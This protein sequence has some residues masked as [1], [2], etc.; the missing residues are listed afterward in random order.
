V[1]ARS[2]VVEAGRLSTALRTHILALADQAVVSAASF[3]TFILVSR[4]T[5]P[6]QLGLYSIAMSVL[7]STLA[8][9]FALISLPFTIQRHR[10]Q[11]TLADHAGTSLMHNGLLSGLSIVLLTTAAFGLSV[12]A[13]RPDTIAIAWALAAT[14]P[15]ALLRE[16]GRRCAFARL[17]MGEALLLDLA[18][19]AFQFGTLYW[20]GS[21]GHISPA[22]ACAAQGAACALVGILWLYLCRADFSIRND[23]ALAAAKQSW[24]LG[25]WF[26]A[27]QA[28]VWLQC[29]ITYWLLAFVHG[30]AATGVYAACMSLASFGNP[31]MTGINNA[32]IP[33]AVLALET[34]G[35]A[36][37]RKQAVRGAVLLGAAMG[38]FCLMLALFSAD[39]MRLIYRGKD[40]DGR[41]DTVAL[42]G[43]GLLVAA[44]GSPASF[45]LA[46]LERPQAIVWSGLLGLVFTVIL[47]LVLMAEWNLFGAAC[48]YATG[49]VAATA[50]LWVAFL[51]VL[52]ERGS[53]PPQSAALAAWTAARPVGH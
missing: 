39:A 51:A 48:G 41:G 31:L 30:S 18:V 40:F 33:K 3:L 23:Q 21:T 46:S 12:S 28:T 19:A 11:G 7:I 13:A 9:Q 4:W 43:F 26:L 15:F 44:V 8:V 42:L 45:G 20:L 50:G 5:N 52:R 24:S 17:R 14:A 32:L 38:L 6:S 35:P 53:Q 27:G 34:G 29:Y 49:C 10:P 37:L 22:A 36:S 16:F 2:G 1:Q 25:R 47:G